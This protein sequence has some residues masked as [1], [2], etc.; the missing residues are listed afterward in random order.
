MV[1]RTT[2]KQLN[3]V[4]EQVK[5]NVRVEAVQAATPDTKSKFTG[6]VVVACNVPSGVVLRLH[7]HVNNPGYRGDS[8]GGI[9]PKM[10]WVADGSKPVIRVRGPSVGRGS[11]AMSIRYAVA[12][13]Y[14]ITTNVPRDYWEQWLEQNKDNPIVFNKMIFATPSASDTEKEAIKLD[15]KS[16]FEPMD[17]SAAPKNMA[18]GKGK[19]L[20][21]TQWADE[22]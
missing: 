21:M 13:G 1:Q 18:T 7:R 15:M 22:E 2:K 16:G 5:N 11:D 8:H 19:H 9:E 10:M 14:G 20:K 6:T 4:K 17:P 3:E 12:G